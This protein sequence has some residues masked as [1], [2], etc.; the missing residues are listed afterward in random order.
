MIKKFFFVIVLII[1]IATIQGCVSVGG[2]PEWVTR[3][4]PNLIDPSVEAERV[5]VAELEARHRQ[6]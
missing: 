1:I 5:T 4:T 6:R 2:D 3:L